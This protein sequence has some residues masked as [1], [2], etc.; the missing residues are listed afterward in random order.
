MNFVYLTPLR[1]RNFVYETSLHFVY[2]PEGAFLT[3]TFL[4]RVAL[5]YTKF[6][7][8]SKRLFMAPDRSRFRPMDGIAGYA[9]FPAS[10]PLRYRIS[11]RLPPCIDC[12]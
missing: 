6:F 7:T 9:L 8:A 12:K 11:A 10:R 2:S 1:V 5:S 4:Q 3:F